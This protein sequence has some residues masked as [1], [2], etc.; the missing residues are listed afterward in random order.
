MNKRPFIS[1]PYTICNLFSGF[2]RYS[3]FVI[4]YWFLVLSV[5]RHSSSGLLHVRIFA[6]TNQRYRLGL[7]LCSNRLGL[8]HG[9]RCFE[10]DKFRSWRRL[11]GGSLCRILCD[12][13]VEYGRRADPLWSGSSIL[14]FHA[15]MRAFGLCD[16]ERRL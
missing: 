12:Q 3:I 15:G 4:R 1:F 10:A 9:L 2:I 6:T 11:H 13:M 5:I 8:Y 16:R 7:N 14:V